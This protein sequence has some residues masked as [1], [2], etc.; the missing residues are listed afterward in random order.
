VLPYR[1]LLEIFL[2]AH[3]PT[4]LDRQ[5][6]DVGPQYRSA[7]F[8]HDEE[9]DRIA[10]ALIAEHD[11]AGT[12]GGRIVTQV[13]PFERFWPAEAYHRRYYRRNPLQPYCAFVISPKVGKLRQKHAGRLRAAPVD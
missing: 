11:A 10:R 3:D 5:G 4:Q 2:A 8:T 13:A 1:D 9:Q 6:N 7:I 12:F